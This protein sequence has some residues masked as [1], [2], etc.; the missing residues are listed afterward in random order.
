MSEQDEKNQGSAVPGRSMLDRRSLKCVGVSA[1]GHITVFLLLFVMMLMRAGSFEADEI[2]IT[3]VPGEEEGEQ[4][5]VEPLV[6]EEDAEIAESTTEMP[7]EE[8]ADIAEDLESI[9][10]VVKP[11]DKRPQDNSAKQSDRDR[12]NRQI[13]ANQQ[14]RSK[15]GDLKPRTF[16]GMYLH[17]KNM[18]FVLDVSGSMDINE[19]RLQLKNA[20]HSL[21]ERENFTIVVY[22][23]N[24]FRWQDELQAATDRNKKEADHWVDTVIVGGSTNLYGGLE[25]GFQIACKSPYTEMYLVSDGEPNVGKVI[26]TNQIVAD[27][28]IWNKRKEIKIHTIGLGMHQRRDFLQALAERNYGRY[29]ER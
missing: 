26:D 7:E 19:A 12:Q 21:T 15:Y 14:A 28:C 6:N 10:P 17:A 3:Y 23:D 20:Y 1:L 8:V 9:A 11:S 4:D 22:S 16:Y 13:E 27:V 29:L 25:T 2:S 18:V 5:S 24:V